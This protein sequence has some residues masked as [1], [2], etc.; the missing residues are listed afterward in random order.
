[1]SQLVLDAIAADVALLERHVDAP[2]GELGYGADLSCAEDLSEDFA[3]VD[4][5]SPR[6]LAEALLRRLDCPR[7]TL[8]E[9]SSPTL[10]AAD[11]GMELQAHLHGPLTL[12]DVRRI[13]GAI[14]NELTK[15]DR[16]DSLTVN[17]TV[18]SDGSSFTVDLQVH[19]VDPRTGEFALTFAVT[20]A[21]LLIEELRS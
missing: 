12:G 15:D 6:A 19:P 14:R 20:T 11:Y 13:E 1:V 18:T 21:A 4:P 5:L 17:V 10:V 16:V 9:A 2:E 8:P 3:D 7:G